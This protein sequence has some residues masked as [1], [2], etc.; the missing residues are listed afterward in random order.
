MNISTRGQ[1]YGDKKLQLNFE[2]G[3]LSEYTYHADSTPWHYHENPYFMYVLEGNMMDINASKKSKIP[4][5]SLIFH[6][7]QDPHLNEKKSKRARGFH[8]EFD[9]SWFDEKQLGINLWEGSQV[10]ENP[11]LHHVLAKIYYEFK[12]KDQYSTLSIEFLLLHLCEKI[13]QSQ[14]VPYKKEPPWIKQLKEIIHGDTNQL[15]LQYLSEQLGVHPVHISRSIP[16]YFNHSLG[17]YIR[18]Q[19]IKRALNFLYD[20]SWSMTQIAY[21]C[22][23]S[24]Q[25]HFTRTFKSYFGKTPGV[26]RNQFTF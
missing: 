14:I 5:G 17:E 7:W 15:S 24:D 2:G 13:D 4:A 19:K 26:F 3:I 21:E 18:Q 20:P 1:Y 22:G 11:A 10:L 25:S 12:T 8:L 9:R 6:N 23:F 16:Q